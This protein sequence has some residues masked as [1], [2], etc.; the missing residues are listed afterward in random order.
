MNVTNGVILY[1]VNGVTLHGGI[2]P[3]F[4]LRLNKKPAIKSVMLF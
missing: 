1:G 2:I 3:G 4:G